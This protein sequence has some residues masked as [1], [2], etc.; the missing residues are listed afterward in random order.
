[1]PAAGAILLL[2]ASLIL[3]SGCGRQPLHLRVSKDVH[4]PPASVVLF[5]PDG[6]DV[7]RMDA[8]LAEGKLPN[9]EKHFVRGGV[10][11]QRAINSIPALTYPNS[12]SLMTGV[13]PGHHG[14]MGNQLFDRRNMYWVDYITAESYLKVNDDFAVPTLYE[15][16]PDH[17]TVNVQ[18]PTHRGVTH[19]LD[20]PVETGIAWFL[21][22]HIEVDQ[23]VA[24]CIEQIGP[25]AERAGRWPSVITFYFPGLDEIGHQN[26]S[27]SAAYRAAILN[28]DYQIG[29]VIDALERAGLLDS[30]HLVLVSDHGQIDARN[31]QRFDLI[32]WLR[33]HRGLRLHYGD[34]P[35]TGYPERAAFLDSYDLMLVDGSARR[36]LLHV[37]GKQ[38]WDESPTEERITQIITGQAE[39]AQSIPNGGAP[40]YEQPGVGLVAARA[41]EDRVRVFARDGQAIIERRR[42]GS[43]R[44]YRILSERGGEDPLGLAE[45]PELSRFITAGWH[46]SREW[47]AATAESRHPD[48][49][50]QIVEYF[51]A[52]TSG[53]IVVFCAEGWVFAGAEPGEHGS[54]LHE[55]MRIPIFFAGPGLPRGAS[56]PHGRLVD[57]MPTVLDLLGESARLQT[58]PKIDGES[59]LPQLRTADAAHGDRVG[60]TTDDRPDPLRRS[61]SAIRAGTTSLDD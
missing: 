45:T 15:R 3:F 48:F 44:E 11:V 38:G 2:Q 22:W 6:L 18:C 53:D 34:I 40:L 20:N 60:V 10:R 37:R 39:A 7:Q 50:P 19:T 8:L 32:D 51:D 43:T 41:G 5:F 36:Y 35:R 24:S 4:R 52:I 25:A 42:A 17:F 21:G 57:V 12:V 46:G 13:F 33:K 23:F 1:M 55:D 58:P 26:G 28:I 54:C 27:G 59:L 29:R 31:L 30:S 16:I 49:V 56:I 61:S 47:L 9:I 14:I